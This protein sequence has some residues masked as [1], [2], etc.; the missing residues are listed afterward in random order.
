MTTKV[1]SSGRPL[2]RSEAALDAVAR[3]RK[4]PPEL[5]VIDDAVV[6][7]YQA[8]PA[9]PP[10]AAG[11]PAPSPY[12]QQEPY[13]TPAEAEQSRETWTL[14]RDNS[15]Q[16][17]QQNMRIVARELGELGV[18]VDKLGGALDNR[19]T[20]HDVTSG[21][22]TLIGVAAS[23][24][25]ANPG[26]A[27]VVTGFLGATLDEINERQRIEEQKPIGADDLGEYAS[28]AA[29]VAADGAE[30]LAKGQQAAKVAKAAGPALSVVAIGF[31]AWEAVSTQSLTIE[32]ARAADSAQLQ[33]LD[34]QVEPLSGRFIVGDEADAVRRQIPEVEKAQRE[35]EEETKRLAFYEEMLG[36]VGTTI[37]R[38]RR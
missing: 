7:R 33:A 11:K 32:S 23:V 34:A 30:W 36:N 22:I 25:S 9:A 16:R 27:L 4:V 1:I 18:L 24:L 2:S 6:G 29:G 20:F 12:D 5:L 26:P 35:L 10:A 17:V 8:V 14:M 19:D 15:R 37:S 21:A 31:T 28:D 13:Q 3:A 38:R